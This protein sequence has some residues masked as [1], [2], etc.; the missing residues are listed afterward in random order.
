MKTLLIV[1]DVIKGIVEEDVK[2]GDILTLGGKSES[3]VVAFLQPFLPLNETDK[4]LNCDITAYC[5]T[6]V[7]KD[8]KKVSMYRE[9]KLAEKI[10]GKPTPA[11]GA[12][13]FFK[14]DVQS[15]HFLAEQKYTDELSYRLALKTWNKISNEAFSKNLI[16]LL[17]ITLNQSQEPFNLIV[18]DIRDFGMKFNINEDLLVQKFYSFFG[19]SKGVTILIKYE[20]V[21][22]HYE[23]TIYNITD[24]MPLYLFQIKDT[25]LIG[26]KSSD[27]QKFQELGLPSE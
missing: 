20:D 1:D 21:F 4:K 5:Y 13:D 17:E 12:L 3:F 11:S 27:F 19:V 26:F 14:G 8:T 6:K 10:N 7:R 15:R 2:Q 24:K 25:L 9:R 22:N 23:S 18:M 16:P